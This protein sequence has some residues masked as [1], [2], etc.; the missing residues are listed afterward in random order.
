VELSKLTPTRLLKE[1]PY[2]APIIKE[3]PPLIKL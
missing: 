2:G 1:A 3:A